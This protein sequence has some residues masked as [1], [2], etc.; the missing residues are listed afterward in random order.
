MKYILSILF[1]F[2]F[3]FF[4]ISSV[5]A[6]LE[7][8]QDSLTPV[9]SGQII[10]LDFSIPGIGSASGN[11]KPQHPTRSVLLNFYNTEVNSEDKSVKPLKSFIASATFDAD[12]SS[13]TF[14]HYVNQSIDLKFDVPDGSYQ[15]TFQVNNSIPTLIKER[16]KD[17]AGKKF[18]IKS[19]YSQAI[20]ISDQSVLT[21]D[22]YPL[23]GDN[24][25]DNKDY[26]ALT[27]CYGAKADSPTCESKNAADLNDDGTIDGTDYNII[28]S[29]FKTLL[30]RGLAVP[31]EILSN[32][33]TPT[34]TDLKK[35]D[36]K[37]TDTPKDNKKAV[38][39]SSS[40]ILAILL[41]VIII[42]AGA[43]L[44]FFLIKRKKP[45]AFDKKLEDKQGQQTGTPVDSI[46][47]VDT[48]VEKEFFVK[49][50][51]VRDDGKNVLM[52]TD[53]NGPM[54]GY[55]TGNVQDGFSKV[56]GIIKKDG[57]KLYMDVTEITPVS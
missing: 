32:Q 8:N 31:T 34:K 44:T 21:G 29:S 4:C 47:H 12:E 42:I 23:G 26:K 43:G 28:S 1:L 57:D 25:I 5:Y 36:I 20:S 14:G 38:K 19:S 40:P 9:P 45:L 16:A 22:V 55:Y 10:K 50:Q 46:E 52:L 33:L 51:T 3:S 6:Q 56:K 35:E 18:E 37:P 48:P 2:I 11:L 39:S 17:I 41:V 7:I 53:D 24:T 30:E 49:K 27:A 13:P 15:I 54:L